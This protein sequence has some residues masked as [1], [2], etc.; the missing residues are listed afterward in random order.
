MLIL[1]LQTWRR[2]KILSLY[3]EFNILIIRVSM[4]ENYVQKWLS[5]CI[6]S[7]F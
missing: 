6:I 7:K 5:D 1:V 2:C 4:S 3:D